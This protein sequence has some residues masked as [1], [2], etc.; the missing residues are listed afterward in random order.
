MCKVY[1]GYCGTCEIEHDLCACTV[2]NPHA[3]ARGLSLRTGAQTMLYLSHVLL[4]S[5]NNILKN[6]F[7][8][9]KKKSI[10]FLVSS[11]G[12]SPGRAIVLT[13]ALAL[14][15]AATSASEKC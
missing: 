7:N 6:Q 5:L 1:N 13:P 4:V 10:Q 11:P 15:S 3:K 8:E 14:A 9:N 12:R 2:D